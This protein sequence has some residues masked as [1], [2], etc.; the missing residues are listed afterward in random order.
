MPDETYENEPIIEIHNENEPA[1]EEHDEDEPMDEVQNRHNDYEETQ[2]LRINEALE[3]D[4]KIQIIKEINPKII[5]QVAKDMVDKW[6]ID[7]TVDEIS[8]HIEEPPHKEVRE[9]QYRNLLDDMEVS[10]ISTFREDGEISDDEDDIPELFS[11]KD[12]HPLTR[13]DQ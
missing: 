7:D 4:D 2:E 8:H 9:D 6:N 1:M 11:T 12:E 10:S 5:D 13:K 3:D